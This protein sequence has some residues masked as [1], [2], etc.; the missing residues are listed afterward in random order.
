MA[1][2]LPPVAFSNNDVNNTTRFKKLIENSY[3]GITLLDEQFNILYRSP[4]AERISGWDTKRRSQTPLENTIHPD[5][6]THVKTT[7][8]E[9]VQL[10]GNSKTCTFRS[11]HAK[12]HYI[13]LECNYTNM[14]NDPDV[15]AIVCNFRDITEKKE[16]SELLQKTIN[17]L[18]A[19]KYALDESAIV[20][21]TDQKGIITHV[22]DN[23]CRISKY[24]AAELVGRDHRIINSSYHDK[25]FMKHLWV[26]IA[27]GNIWRGDLKNKAKDGS[28]YWVDT[29]IVPFLNEKGKPYQYIAIRSD[30]TKK[31]E[32]EHRLKLLESV[33]THTADAVMIT[34]AEP[35]DEPGPRILYVNDAFTRMTDYTA[36]EVIGKSPRIL[37][38]K[39]SDRNEL[40]K[41][42]TH[43]LNWQPYETTIINYKK[44]G[45]EFWVNFSVSAVTDEKGWYTHWI[46]VQ[47]DVTERLNYIKAIEEQNEKLKEISWMQSHVIRAPL[48]RI[49]GLIQMMKTLNIEQDKDDIEKTLQYVMQSANELDEVIKNITAKTGGLG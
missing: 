11:Q 6:L 36:A 26:T 41:L 15:K 35:Q 18:F 17:E 44:N 21:I 24:S 20:A 31:K 28:Y 25:K 5:D 37:Q 13:W 47:R 4:S 49:M 48:S 27:N 12:G 32:E 1:K 22:N 10:T 8:N 14:L 9:I 42:K 23:F 7:L 46:A 3:E 16:A 33:I 34:E 30:I 29:T 43:L 40:Q 45:E 19:F 2:R 38:G 39:R